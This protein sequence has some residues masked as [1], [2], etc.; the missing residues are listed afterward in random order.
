ME[1]RPNRTALPVILVFIIIAGILAI[2]FYYLY[3]AVVASLR[4]AREEAF[5]YG[6]LGAIG[7]SI[8]IYMTYTIGRRR[9]SQKPLPKVVT[10]TECKKCGFKSLK[11]FEKGDYAFKTVGNCQKCSEPMLVTAIYAEEAKRQGRRI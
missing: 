7:L 6:L 9:I 11:K 8:S 2:S 5:Y 10:V 1:K 3:G 4:G